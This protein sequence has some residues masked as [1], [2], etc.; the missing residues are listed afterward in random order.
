MNYNTE[1][2]PNG[3]RLI[4]LPSGSPVVYLGYQLAVGSRNEASGQ[5]GLAHLCEHMTFKGTATRS[6]LQVISEL[7]RVGGDLN[8]FTTKDTTTYYAA[9]MQQHTGRAVDLLTDIVFHSVYPES[10]LEHERDVVCDEIE[11]YNDSPA[12]LIYDEFEN[13]LFAGTPLGHNILGTAERVRQ[14]CHDD[15]MAFARR[16]YRPENAV[17]FVYGDI[18]FRWLVRRLTR[19]TADIEQAAPSS[20]E[21]T[22]QHP[23]PITQHPTPIAQ[24]SSPNNHHQMHVMIGTRAYAHSD[25]RRMALFVLNNLLG[26]PAMSARLNL[27]LR[28]RHGL[29][30]TVESSMVSYADTGSWAIY[31]G[32]DHAD[33][34]RCLRLVRRELDRVMSKPLSI[35]QLT[36]AKQQLKGQIGIAVDNHEQFALDFGRSYLHHGTER[37]L[38]RL[39]ADIDAVTPEDVQQVAQELFA[40]ERLLTHVIG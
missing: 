10:E 21:E 25:H 9:V 34:K 37:H 30:Y 20:T 35:R 4:H 24:P 23:L 39:F 31:F 32:C 17:F 8:A 15:L 7:E 38:S 11:S 36:A 13:V 12:E 33:A 5:E 14:F 22:I 3:L 29:V 40:E 16:W 28:E 26:G 2:L 1:T 19:L 6:A 27:S 18:D